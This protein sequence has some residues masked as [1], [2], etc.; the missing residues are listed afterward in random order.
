[1]KKNI[2]KVQRE[3]CENRC[4]CCINI[5]E[6]VDKR[7][8]YL[9]FSFTIIVQV[10]FVLAI[11]QTSIKNL[12]DGKH[13]F[14]LIVCTLLQ[15]GQLIATLF[16]VLTLLAQLKRLHAYSTWGVYLFT[17]V[18]FGG[19]YF[20]LALFSL[21]ICTQ[22]HSDEYCHDKKNFMDGE[23]FSF[24]EIWL[25]E[26]HIGK[27]HQ[28][29]LS[30]Q[31][32][33][34]YIVFIKFLYFSMTTQSSV[35]F[36]DI[37]P[38]SVTARFLA[39]LQMFIGLFFGSIIV[40]MNLSTLRKAVARAKRKRKLTNLSESM[41]HRLGNHN[42]LDSSFASNGG[43]SDRLDDDINNHR[44]R[45]LD[46][47]NTSGHGSTM[48]FNNVNASRSHSTRKHNNKSRQNSLDRK[49]KDSCK[50]CKICF[51]R[52]TRLKWV[53]KVRRFIRKWLLFVSCILQALHLLLLYHY[54][55]N[56]FSLDNDNHQD[57]NFI[58]S[59]FIL[60][61]F[62]Q[63]L[64][65]S[66]VVSTSLKYVRHSE[67]ITINFLVQS[68]ISVCVLFAGMYI[69]VFLFQKQDAWPLKE[70]IKASAGFWYVSGEFLYLSITTM[71]TTGY[72][73]LS[74]RSTFA[75]AIVSLQIIASAMF[76][77]IIIALGVNMMTEQMDV[78]SSSSSS[79]DEDNGYFDYG[80]DDE[81][82]SVEQHGRHGSSS[83]SNFKDMIGRGTDTDVSEVE[84]R[85]EDIV[86]GM[87]D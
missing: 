53:T 13:L 10:C 28:G 72:G 6:G 8:I 71:T 48:T 1:M 42:E 58:S 32:K 40:S 31:D 18:A 16:A 4:S 21:S 36:G 62:I 2:D 83:G 14:I 39:N 51:K 49:K 84:G 61:L 43:F 3:C 11:E 87:S 68:F 57:K 70:G 74:P 54:D 23:I 26:E 30:L 50:G 19:I 44:E 64:H 76:M 22:V 56:L 55:P 80:L 35:G 81:M 9:F 20:S 34:P 7:W 52:V 47:L 5:L 38:V 85:E 65:L 46:I 66:M 82:E 45:S 12:I 73:D 79:D 77:Q 67:N 29:L 37:V 15:M 78:N 86:S 60:S 33:T 59:A 41:Y 75:I 25:D 24:S 27:H 17:I 69:M 63:I